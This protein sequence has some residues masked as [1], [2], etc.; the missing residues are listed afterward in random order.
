MVSVAASGFIAPKLYVNL[1]KAFEDPERLELQP[2]SP[3]D[4]AAA[5]SVNDYESSNV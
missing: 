3:L 1:G 2:T 4:F 5:A